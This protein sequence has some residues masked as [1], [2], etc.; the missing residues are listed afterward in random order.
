MKT[1]TKFILGTAV[2]VI[3]IIF[4]GSV[5]A[6]LSVGSILEETVDSAAPGP[7]VERS[8]SLEGFTALEV[9]DMWE[10]T[11]ARG[12]FSVSVQAPENLFEHLD[13]E[14][15]GAVLHLHNGRG[16]SN[17]KLRAS[18]SM[19]VLEALE[20]SGVA[21]ADLSD[22]ETENFAVRL[23]GASKILS[24]GGSFGT[25]ELDLSGISK[26]DFSQTPTTH[27]S[28]DLS[29]TSK[30]EL[31]MLGGLLEGDVSGASSLAYRG[32]VSSEALDISGASRVSQR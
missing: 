4:V 29:G 5:A 25:L 23:S 13:V 16:D 6:R 27:A 2:A 20:M 31:W 18:V 19:P 32:H 30:A 1:S 11:I 10:V 24:R 3:G 8:F 14:R 21:R 7:T 26:V 17:I 22:M 15:R 12:K 9:S 28:V